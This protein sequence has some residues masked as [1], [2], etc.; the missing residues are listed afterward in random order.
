MPLKH[1]ER[2]Y[3][4]HGG[5]TDNPKEAL[6]DVLWAL[7]RDNRQFQPDAPQSAA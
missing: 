3:V 2:E 4:R 6:S 5:A 7:L 1:R